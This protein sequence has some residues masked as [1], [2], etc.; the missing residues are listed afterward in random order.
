MKIQ[1]GYNKDCRYGN[2]HWHKNNRF[3]GTKHT[4]NLTES[5]KNRGMLRGFIVTEPDKNGKRW[6]LDV[7][8]GHKACDVFFKKNDKV[9]C[10]VIPEHMCDP[11]DDTQVKHMIMILNRNRKNWKIGDYVFSHSLDMGGIYTKIADCFKL[12]K[13]SKKVKGLSPGVVCTSF[14]RLRDTHHEI[15]DGEF[16]TYDEGRDWKF[17][18]GM[19]DFFKNK[20][21]KLNTVGNKAKLP[22]NFNRE[23]AALFWEQIE[24]WGY[25]YNKFLSLLTVTGTTLV[26][27]A[28]KGELP[29][30]K[31][32]ISDWFK[33]IT[34]EIK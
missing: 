16:T 1:M 5:Y 6:L 25:D 33:D 30:N 14:D 13:S 19:L 2:L 32:M 15:R 34:E 24:K 22:N 12:Y 11:N 17:T 7:S 29:G 31:E 10:Y 21:N 8:H 9:P 28:K 27:S 23:V 20:V 3:E 18:E 26:I 4:S